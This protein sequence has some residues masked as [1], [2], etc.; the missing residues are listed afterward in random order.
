MRR[1]A[2]QGQG[3]AALPTPPATPP[4]PARRPYLQPGALAR[5]AA[6]TRRAGQGGS[7][8]VLCPA[9]A[10]TGSSAAR[11][12][13]AARPAQAEPAALPMRAA[14]ESS[15]GRELRGAALPARA[16]ARAQRA[17]ARP[18]AVPP[19]M[20]GGPCL[21]ECR[22]HSLCLLHSPARAAPCLRTGA[23]AQRAFARLRAVPPR[24]LR[25][26]CRAS[27]NAARPHSLCLLHSPARAGPCH[28][29]AARISPVAAA[30]AQDRATALER[31]AAKA[32]GAHTPRRGGR[33]RSVRLR[34]R[35]APIRRAAARPAQEKARCCP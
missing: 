28:R 35:A 20:L 6:P 3:A 1:L 11:I 21:R 29:T 27:A 25:G 17:F 33:A 23:R 34:K 7:C 31:A 12:R 32:G 2:T 30:A 24:M 10:C 9:S 13:L 26:P 4:T 18:R 5:L 8:E 15:Q 19:R 22:P 16:R 14:L